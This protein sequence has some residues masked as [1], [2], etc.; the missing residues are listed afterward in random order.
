VRVWTSATIPKITASG[1]TAMMPSTSAAI[2]KPLVPRGCGGGYPPY[3]AG[4]S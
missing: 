3:P 2:A 1:M 4:G